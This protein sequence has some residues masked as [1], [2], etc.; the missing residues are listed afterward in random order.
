MLEI[1]EYTEWL[2]IFMATEGGAVT[3]PSG[4]LR[5]YYFNYLVNVTSISTYVN[6]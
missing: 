6:V 2:E 5:H 4:R 3:P 1:Y